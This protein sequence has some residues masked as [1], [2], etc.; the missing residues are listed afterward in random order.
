MISLQG[1]TYTSAVFSACDNAPFL[2]HMAEVMTRVFEKLHFLPAPVA[3]SLSRLY[4]DLLGWQRLFEIMKHASGVQLDTLQTTP[5][6]YE[7]M[8]RGSG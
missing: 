6:V 7:K 3:E 4:G 2:R 1:S 8:A 5:M